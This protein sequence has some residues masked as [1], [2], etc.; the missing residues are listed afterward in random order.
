MLQQLRSE[1]FIGTVV[2]HREFL[3]PNIR[4]DVCTK[5]LDLTTL[6][7]GDTNVLKYLLSRS[8]HSHDYLSNWLSTQKYVLTEDGL[9]VVLYFSPDEYQ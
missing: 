8:G 9:Q 6:V 3:G 5:L 2:W 1:S 4:E 7:D